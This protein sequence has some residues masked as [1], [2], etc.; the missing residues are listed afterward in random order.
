M[1]IFKYAR[2]PCRIR[3]AGW[4]M[5]KL[6]R[7]SFRLAEVSFLAVAFLLLTLPVN[8]LA[9]DPSRDYGSAVPNPLQ[10]TLDAYGKGPFCAGCHNIPYPLP[11]EMP[12]APSMYPVGA[13]GGEPGLKRLTESLGRD[14]ERSIVLRRTR[15]SGSQTV[16]GT[17]LSGL[18]MMME[19]ASNS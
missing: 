5:H 3:E 7:L 2:S 18:W 8:T 9:Q 13:Y 1:S 11:P 15:S 14:V 6:N 12:A 17:G 4:S 10:R 16:W 19:P